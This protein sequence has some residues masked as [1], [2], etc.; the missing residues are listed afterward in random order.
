MGDSINFACCTYMYL[1]GLIDINSLSIGICSSLT[2]LPGNIKVVVL[3]SFEQSS[4]TI[5]RERRHRI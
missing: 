4:A 2:Q 5:L 3:T 1:V